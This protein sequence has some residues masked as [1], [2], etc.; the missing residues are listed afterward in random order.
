MHRFCCCGSPSH[1]E[2]DEVSLSSPPSR[3]PAVPC[4]RRRRISATAAS[5][6]AA[7]LEARRSPREALR[8]LAPSAA[9]ASRAGD[10]VPGMEA[11][12]SHA[13]SSVVVFFFFVSKEKKKRERRV[14]GVVRKRKKK[15][16]THLSLLSPPLSVLN[17]LLR[18]L[19]RISPSRASRALDCEVETSAKAASR[20]AR[21][22]VSWFCF[23]K[24][25]ERE[26]EREQKVGVDVFSPCSSRTDCEGRNRKNSLSFSPLP[27]AFSLSPSTSTAFF[28]TPS[29]RVGE[30]EGGEGAA[31]FPGEVSGADAISVERE[32]NRR[33]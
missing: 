7:R 27:I 5:T 12:S 28:A 9:A 30:E 24:E 2:R 11:A 22:A 29:V 32:S 26:R 19:P 8:T 17:L 15:K 31:V 1:D 4:R 18:S 3:A 33:E 13:A 16:K 10:S 20:E 6:R 23:L 25:R 21:D 14:F